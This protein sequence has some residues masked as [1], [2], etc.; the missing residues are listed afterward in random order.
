MSCCQQVKDVL[1]FGKK[2]HAS[3]QECYAHLEGK[4]D[5]ERIRMLLNHLARHEKNLEENLARFSADAR[6]K[7]LGAWLNHVPQSKMDEL[8]GHCLV[9]QG[10][11]VDDVIRMAMEF[12]DALIDLYRE[13]AREAT[14]TDVKQVFLNLV[15]QEN[16]QKLNLVQSVNQLREM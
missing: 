1:D 4:S 9:L 6:P 8:V 7:I 14:N 2:M 15:D 16:Q 5:Q 3:I 13:V 12:D 10:A 11:S